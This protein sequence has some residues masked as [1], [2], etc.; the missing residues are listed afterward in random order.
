MASSKRTPKPAAESA[1][2]RPAGT[3]YYC[4][5]IERPAPVFNPSVG[6]HRAR[7]IV[8]TAKKWVNGTKLKYYFFNGPADGSPASWKGTTAMKNT[9][10]QSFQ[11]WKAVGIGLEFEETN[12]KNEAQVRIGFMR[13]DGSWSY[14][15]T[16]VIDVA[17]SPDERTMNFGWDISQDP[18]TALHE[19]GH[20]LGAP[21]EHQNPNAGIVWNEEAVY[22]ALAGSPNFW[23]RSK[24]FHNI[25]R[26]IPVAQVMGS[27]HDANSIMHYPFEAGLILAPAAFVNGITPAGGLSDKDKEFVKKFYPPLTKA[28]YTE[29]KLAKSF[30]LTINAGQQV[31]LIFKPNR[32]RKYKIE[33]FG[34]MDTLLVLFEKNGTEEIYLSGDDDSG[35]D[36]NS[37]I[38]YRLIKGREYIIRLRLYYSSDEG[39][40]SVMVY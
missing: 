25:I 11:T 1:P 20:T 40:T 17:P 7:M 15:G 30:P 36:T 14:V 38:Q 35:L 22:E 19:I 34:A 13:N 8:V 23:P 24:T 5:M 26:K 18:D 10:K 27:T 12:D 4:S 32:S 28:D 2:A 29:I 31:N 16:D 6:E 9:V 37:M 39:A 21:H 3:P 33:T